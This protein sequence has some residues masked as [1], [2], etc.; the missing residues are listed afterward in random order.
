MLAILRDRLVCLS[1]TSLKL[2]GFNASQAFILIF[3][4]NKVL[5][6]A[7][8]DLDASREERHT[9]IKADGHP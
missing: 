6:V 5:Y 3:V 4:C 2:A 9:D 1:V 8:T 7:R